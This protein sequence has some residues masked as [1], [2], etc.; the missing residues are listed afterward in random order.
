MPPPGVPAPRARAPSRPPAREARAAPP[1]ASTPPVPPSGPTP[2]ATTSALA[3]RPRRTLRDGVRLHLAQGQH[4]TAYVLTLNNVLGAATGFLFWLLLARVAGLGTV[5]MGVGYAAVA[6]GTLIGVVAKGGLDTALIQMV[7]GT[8]R[9]QGRRLLAVSL[10]AGSGAAACI[11]VALA[12]AARA[13]GLFP[14]FSWLAWALIAAIAILLAASWMQDAYFVALGLAGRSLERNL[15]LSAGRL[16][17]PLPMVALAVAHPVPLTWTLALAASALVGLARSRAV[18]DRPGR[19]VPARSFLRASL[20]NIAGGAAEFLPGLL[21]VPLVLAVDG[22][23]AAAYFGIAWTAAALLFQTSAA[24]GRS[25][26]AHMVREQAPGLPA[27]IRRG[28]VEHVLVV[29]PVAIAVAILAPQF[30]GLFGPGYAAH[31]AVVLSVLCLSIVFVAPTSLYLAVLRARRDARAL[32]VFPLAMMASLA[33]LAP[34]LDA[35]FGFVGVAWAWVLA[36]APFGVYAAWRLRRLAGVMP[37][38][39]PAPVARALDVE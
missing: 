19:H 36:S 25:A 38:A 3:S 22:P 34:L 27:A 29:A 8:S 13:S 24:I 23:A 28:A 10:A 6:L 37:L 20:R 32:V 21:L 26:F 16:L 7:P 31:G 4:R 2:E 18:P 14:E 11:T 15:A 1:G 5:A 39:R 17:L 30:L 12:L 9:P 35:R 33:L